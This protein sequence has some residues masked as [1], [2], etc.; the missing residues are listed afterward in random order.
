[1]KE[2]NYYIDETEL[3][4]ELIHWKNSATNPEDRMPSERLGQLLIALH[5]NVLRHHNFNRYRQDL[6]EEMKSYSLFRILKCGLQSFDPDK[7]KAFSYF[8]RSIFMNYIAV[9]KR[10]YNRLNR[11]QAYIQGELMKLDTHGDP[12]LEQL[13]AHFGISG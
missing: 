7:S 2:N 6:K 8:T 11:H 10:Y 5:D 13:I 9:I 4:S 3:K 12:H 1:M